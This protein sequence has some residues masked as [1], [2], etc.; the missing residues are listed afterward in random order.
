MEGAKVGTWVDAISKRGVDGEMISKRVV[1][2]EQLLS[3]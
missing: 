1:L 2:R 3:G